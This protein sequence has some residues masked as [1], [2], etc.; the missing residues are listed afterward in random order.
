MI[1][2]YISVLL[3]KRMEKKML[4][5]TFVYNESD[6][7]K[8]KR[9]QK[10]HRTWFWIILFGIGICAELNW[11]NE[12]GELGTRLGIKGRTSHCQPQPETK[13]EIQSS[14]YLC[15][16][17]HCFKFKQQPPTPRHCAE[18]VQSEPDQWF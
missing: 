10:E 3:T 18:P 4:N 9:E 7:R 6:T 11:W 12:L 14:V 1:F 16:M 15:P 8:R 5:R 2:E 13:K 17:G